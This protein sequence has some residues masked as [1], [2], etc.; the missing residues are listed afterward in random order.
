MRVIITILIVLI[1]FTPLFGQSSF[2]YTTNYKIFPTSPGSL[3]FGLNGYDNPALLTYMKRPD[4]YFIWNTGNKNYFNLNDYGLFTGAKNFGFTYF[5]ENF[6]NAGRVENY[7]LSTSFGNKSIA[8]GF[9]Y[10]W[11]K[12]KV[13]GISNNN[14]LTFGALVRPNKLISLG[15]VST[16]DKNFN[17]REYA[18]DFAFRPFGNEKLTLFADYVNLK[19]SNLKDSHWSTGIVVEPFDGIQFTGRYFD[20]SSISMGV[21]IS[22]GN[23]SLLQTIILDKKGKQLNEIQGIRLGSYDRN[24]ISKLM[25]KEKSHQIDLNG[26]IKYQK[27]QMFDKSKTL[28]E[29]LDKLDKIKNDNS[30]TQIE[31]N[32]SGL[33]ASKVF[34]WELRDK[35]F[36]LKKYDK[37]IIIYIDNADMSLYHF[38]SVADKI[39]MDPL[40]IVTLEGL[41][42]GKNFYKGTLEKLGIGFDELRFFKYKSAAETFGREKMSDA[43]REQRQLII[44]NLYETIKNNIE[45]SRKN[46]KLPFDSLMNNYVL[47]DSKSALEFGLVDSLA[48]WYDLKDDSKLK[49]IIKVVRDN[50]IEAEII[51]EDNYW[52]EKP[53]IAIVYTLGVCDMDE[54]IKARSLIKDIEKISKDNSIK[55][56]VF[57]I[58]S[59]GGDALASDVIAEAMK[60]LKK[61]KPVIVSQGLV[62]GSGGYWLSM[63][64][65]TIVS[66][67]NTI[68]GSIGVIASWFYNKGFKESAGV[69]TDFVKR[70]EHADLGFGMMVPILNVVIPDR[71][72]NNEEKNKL[73]ILIRDMYKN[74]V[75][76]VSEG[77]NK[78]SEEIEKV[79]QGR[80]WSGV[81]AIKF[82]L[83]DVLG[84]LETAIEIAREKANLKKNEFQIVEFPKPQLLDLSSLIPLPVSARHIK[85]PFME[86][87]E[88]D[89]KNSG[90]PKMMMPIDFIPEENLINNFYR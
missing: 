12:S 51:N 42:M 61:S 5:S 79:A 69:S 36:E 78:Q 39:I 43:D 67:R 6:N 64:A 47:F 33:I 65:D 41:L 84:G 88:F 62:A 19:I 23:M 38:A 1:S 46:L 60:K 20:N 80:V 77:R 90:K 66:N 49:D 63:N 26:Q 34:L 89:L 25:E 44:D 30:I 85:S 74:F 35:L 58:D 24:I 21:Q 13:T 68:T 16:T 10:Q 4:I 57:R 45:S 86:M 83:V 18:I 56:V 55:A 54:G 28:Y 87:I 17:D 8:I 15:L 59:P 22:L 76:K 27:F 81:D 9:A 72:L 3:R 40:G 11:I 31:I 7:K 48:R 53:K 37:R 2:P 52:G 82:G 32:T 50:T 29:L 75:E 70:G 73:E 71:K 14:L